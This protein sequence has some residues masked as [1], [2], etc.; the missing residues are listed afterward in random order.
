MSREQTPSRPLSSSERRQSPIPHALMSPPPSSHPFH[1]PGNPISYKGTKKPQTPLGSTVNTSAEI[2]IQ[3]VGQIEQQMGKKLDFMTVPMLA[4]DSDYGD[5][6]S[7]STSEVPRYLRKA[8]RSRSAMSTYSLGKTSRDSFA[9]IDYA[10]SDSPSKAASEPHKRGHDSTRPPSAASFSSTLMHPGISPAK[11]TNRDISFLTDERGT[12]VDEIAPSLIEKEDYIFQ[13]AEPLGDSDRNDNIIHEG[14]RKFVQVFPSRKPSGR[15]DAIYL[16]DWLER[17]LQKLIS[18][19]DGKYELE[20]DQVLLI[21]LNEVVRQVSVQCDER[22]QVLK[23]MWMLQR[24]IMDKIRHQNIDQSNDLMQLKARLDVTEKMNRSLEAQVEKLAKTVEEKNGNLREADASQRKREIE[25]L[26][27]QVKLKTEVDSLERKERLLVREHQEQLNAERKRLEMESDMIMDE[28]ERKLQDLID[29]LKIKEKDLQVV[30]YQK[31]ALE[32]EYNNLKVIKEQIE[33]LQQEANAQYDADHGDDAARLES[34]KKRD[35]LEGL[36][37]LV[38]QTESIQ[39]IM[40]SAANKASEAI[41]ADE[42]A[43]AKDTQSAVD[44]SSEV[45]SVSD[46]LKDNQKVS[47]LRQ[48]KQYRR[49]IEKYVSHWIEFTKL[50]K[51]GLIFPHRHKA[52]QIESQDFKQDQDTMMNT[53]IFFTDMAAHFETLDPEKGYGNNDYFASTSIQTDPMDVEFVAPSRKAKKGEFIYGS[54]IFSNTGRILSRSF[55]DPELF[56]QKLPF[57]AENPNTLSL[58]H[59]DESSTAKTYHYAIMNVNKSCQTAIQTSHKAFQTD[60]ADMDTAYQAIQTSPEVAFAYCQ[61]VA[62][63][64]EIAIDTD[65]LE[66]DPYPYDSYIVSDFRVGQEGEVGRLSASSSFIRKHNRSKS[67]SSFGDDDG[68]NDYESDTSATSRSHMQHDRP[69]SALGVENSIMDRRRLSGANKRFISPSGSFVMSQ[70]VSQEQLDSV[71]T[72]QSLNR[73][74]S[75]LLMGEIDKLAKGRNQNPLLLVQRGSGLLQK[76]DEDPSFFISGARGQ[77]PNM[78]AMFGDDGSN[79]DY[80]GMTF[81]GN[82]AANALQQRRAMNALSRGG[83]ENGVRIA[84]NG[85]LQGVAG[86]P[87]GQNGKIDEK[88][89]SKWKTATIL[90]FKSILQDVRKLRT[91][92]MSLWSLRKLLNQIYEERIKSVKNDPNT[93]QVNAAQF[94]YNYVFHRYGLKT[95]ALKNLYNLV[96]NIDRYRTKDEAI[97]LFA[98]LT[99]IEDPIPLDAFNGLI[100]FYALLQNSMVLPSLALMQRDGFYLLLSRIEPLVSSLRRTD[101]L[102]R[103][104][105]IPVFADG[106]PY[107]NHIADM[108]DYCLFMFSQRWRPCSYLCV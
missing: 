99:G 49:M 26:K 50:A 35:A 44:G 52:C 48:K 45:N 76:A 105:L 104:S 60:K 81:A 43:T 93:L 1:H 88:K 42:R 38:S 36:F 64:S 95:L 79:Y 96:S 108:V 57:K 97:F 8:M 69:H 4:S 106:S 16:R 28:L 67:V 19:T 25:Y 59:G 24:E 10:P 21:G 39:T 107:P 9:S 33:K 87:N 46:L 14:G 3:R 73:R 98:R 55:S 66:W 101:S 85:E 53:N 75:S 68:A 83:S 56:G 62:E 47:K 29:E 100:A 61:C 17:K 80:N 13:P 71:L 30:T 40:D 102:I 82:F 2:Q 5:D 23:R 11:T 34:D 22:G 58:L 103:A 89:D 32:K 77:Q 72:G 6:D 27:R 65:D 51:E 84:I 12:S 74:R 70:S 63:T 20:L 18:S 37:S 15:G 94:A 7:S 41:A 31:K 91:T 86:K 54:K 78:R 92:A 90:D